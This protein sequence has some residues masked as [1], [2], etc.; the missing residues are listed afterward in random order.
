MGGITTGRADG[1]IDGTEDIGNIL[2]AW[3]V[4]SRIVWRCRPMALGG[5]QP[6]L[7]S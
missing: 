6:E 1:W 7:R 4:R 5:S 3:E 2:W